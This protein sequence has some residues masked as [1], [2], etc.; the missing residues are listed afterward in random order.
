MI[1]FQWIYYSKSIAT[2]CLV[3][4]VQLLL[5]DEDNLCHDQLLRVP[6]RF[7]EFC[8]ILSD[9]W[10]SNRLVCAFWIAREVYLSYI[11]NILRNYFLL[12]SKNNATPYDVFCLSR[13]LCARCFYMNRLFFFLLILYKN[14][15]FVIY[16]VNHF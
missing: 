5:L 13:F 7:S 10:C 6:D 9:A 11:Q 8:E 15:N 1:K 3:I 4:E 16:I 2:L 14:V 12:W